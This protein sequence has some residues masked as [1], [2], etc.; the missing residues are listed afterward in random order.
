M[1]EKDDLDPTAQ[2]IAEADALRKALEEGAPSVDAD[3][4][5]SL[6]LSHAPGD[7]DTNQ[8]DAIVAAALGGK[9]PER[10]GIVIRVAF[11][12]AAAVAIAAGTIVAIRTPLEQ[13]SAQLKRVRSTQDL[14]DRPFESNAT[15]A[16]VD[17]IA[18]MRGSDLRENHFAKWGVR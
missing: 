10:R 4:L 7:I 3:F 9:K 6:K 1:P 15:S 16:R 5:R 2:E 17:R 18:M 13:P 8:H 12:I 11:G 14:F